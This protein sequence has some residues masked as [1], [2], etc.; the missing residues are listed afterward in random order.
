M[1]TSGDQDCME[2]CDPQR[3]G[4]VVQREGDALTLLQ[5]I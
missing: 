2:P 3:P 1:S 4:S 5:P